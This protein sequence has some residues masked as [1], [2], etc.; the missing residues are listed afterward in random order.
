MVS[1]TLP[2]L[3]SPSG[4]PGVPEV[5]VWGR[6]SEAT[7]STILPT[8]TVTDPS[9]ELSTAAVDQAMVAAGS[10]SGDVVED[11]KLVD[12]VVVVAAVVVVVAGGSVMLIA[13]AEKTPAAVGSTE[14]A[15]RL[16]L[17]PTY[18]PAETQPK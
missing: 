8:G 6:V 13:A 3:N 4:A 18:G 2:E 10:A 17:L 1:V 16:L 5:T 12:V 11:A 14:D 9:P 15:V 7:H